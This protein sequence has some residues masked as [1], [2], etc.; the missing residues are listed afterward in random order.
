MNS[1]WYDILLHSVGFLG[2]IA[3][4]LSFQ[5]RKH[6]PLILFRSAN[7][8]LFAVQYAM[9]GAYTG[10]AMNLIGTVRNLI[11]ADMVEKRKNTT[12]VRILFSAL[13]LIFIGF[14]WSG[15]KSV[16]FGFGKVVT[17]FAYGSS[18]TS[19]VRIMTFFTSCTFFIYNFMAKSYAGCVCEFF[20]LCSIIVGIVRLDV[21]KLSEKAA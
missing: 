10:M 11:F 6:K 13:F 14:T 20:T 18:K 15:M 2:I 1:L 9:L 21:M 12:P 3:S 17:T 4:I 5:C 19:V 7:E 16:L 8:V